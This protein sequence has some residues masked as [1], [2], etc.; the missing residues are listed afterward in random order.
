MEKGKIVAGRLALFRDNWSKVTRDSWVLDT[1]MGYR[2]EFLVNP[3][4][5]QA[6][7]WVCCHLQSN[8]SYNRR[9]RSCFAR[10]R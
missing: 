3:S 9:Y 1:E 6:Q 10:A 2:I 5:S 4:N 8:T 7:E